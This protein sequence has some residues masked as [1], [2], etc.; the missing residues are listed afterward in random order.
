[1]CGL[2]LIVSGDCCFFGFGCADDWL[3]CVWVMRIALFPR[4]G[5]CGVFVVALVV[6]SG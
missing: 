5:C 6:V 3:V 1:M 2:F 4:F